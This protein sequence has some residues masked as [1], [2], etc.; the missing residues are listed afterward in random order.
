MLISLASHHVSVDRL[1]SA[2]SRADRP[3]WASLLS[4][5]GHSADRNAKEPPPSMA[6]GEKR[7]GTAIQCHSCSSLPPLLIGGHDQQ[8]HLAVIGTKRNWKMCL[9]GS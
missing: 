1:S 5:R 4:T 9:V 2:G 8:K 6:S 7:S 3:S